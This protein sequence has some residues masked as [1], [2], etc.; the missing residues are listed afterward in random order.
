M[1]P[2]INTPVNKQSQ[3][4]QHLTIGTHNHREVS[5]AE[6]S[7]LSSLRKPIETV[8]HSLTQLFSFTDAARTAI[9]DR[10]GEEV[11]QCRDY[12]YDAPSPEQWQ[13]KYRKVTLP[14]NSDQMMQWVI[15]N[16]RTNSE[17]VATT[18]P[19]LR[20]IELAQLKAI[21]QNL[22]KHY[23]V[24]TPTVHLIYEIFQ[25]KLLTKEQIAKVHEFFRQLD[26]NHD[27]LRVVDFQ[28]V[29]HQ[30]FFGEDL[31]RTR[32]RIIESQ[33]NGLFSRINISN[34]LN[35]VLYSKVIY[36]NYHYGED[37]QTL[38]HNMV[39]KHP[40]LNSFNGE[41]IIRVY[42][43]EDTGHENMYTQFKQQLDNMSLAEL[44]SVALEGLHILPST[45]KGAYIDLHRT[46]LLY[47]PEVTCNCE[48]KHSLI[49]R[50]FD[51]TMS[52]PM[53]DIEL[54]PGEVLGLSTFVSFG[55]AQECHAIS[56]VMESGVM[57]VA[58][59]ENPKLKAVLDR[60]L[61]ELV[62]AVDS[63][64][65]VKEGNVTNNYNYV[66]NQL[67]EMLVDRDES[68]FRHS[69]VNTLREDVICPSTAYPEPAVPPIS[70]SQD[71]H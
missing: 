31:S 13:E 34:K 17:R 48:Q 38:W 47:N 44:E 43:S 66:Y 62:D 25:P 41:D 23:P 57:G 61:H 16:D 59:G 29:K 49:H 10:R 53:P 37:K 21:L 24:N 63:G 5:P 1:T 36:F 51:T 64:S 9:T 22:E 18:S 2:I 28:E 4:S 35:D 15:F 32:E 6:Q 67:A 58:E 7:W 27:N 54:S 12:Y 8:F 56:P 30:F 69:E 46:V 55:S 20:N 42:D 65:L 19:P 60:S 52:G 68:P 45:L 39:E 50:D 40:W 33:N 26:Q 11:T 70:H 71:R 14:G 3:H